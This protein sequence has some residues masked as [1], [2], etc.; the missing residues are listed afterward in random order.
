MIPLRIPGGR[1]VSRAG[2]P[3]R[4]NVPNDLTV[5]DLPGDVMVS[6]WEV[7][8][9]EHAMLAHGGVVELFMCGHP[10]YPAPP[11]LLGVAPPNLQENPMP[12]PNPTIPLQLPLDQVNSIL[13]VL[14]KQPFDTV[15]DLIIDLRQQTGQAIEAYQRQQGPQ[16]QFPQSPPPSPSNGADAPS[17]AP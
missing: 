1:T 5:L 11:V 15:A 14:G 13:S 12:S 8:P 16:Q 3:G 2:P 10:D 6:H 9:H 17:P 4:D 7:L